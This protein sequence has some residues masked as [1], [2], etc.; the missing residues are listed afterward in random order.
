MSHKA[1]RFMEHALA[2]TTALQCAGMK[3]DSPVVHAKFK[4]YI[5]A[6]FVPRI[7]DAC[8]KTPCL[9]TGAPFFFFSRNKICMFFHLGRII[10]PLYV[11]V[12]V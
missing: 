6:V 1:I 5:S 4:D 9:V 12:F 11:V 8:N 2:I 3:V 7:A 10:R